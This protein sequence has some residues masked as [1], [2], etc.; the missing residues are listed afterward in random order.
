MDA[1][2][3]KAT[4]YS[5]ESIDKTWYELIDKFPYFI[6][7]DEFILVHAGFDFDSPEPYCETDEMLWIRDFKYNKQKALNKT[8]IRG[9]VPT[10]LETIIKNVQKRE[11]IISLDNGC[12]YTGIDG[13]GHLL[14]LNLNT[15]ELIIQPNIDQ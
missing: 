3:Q 13:L 5:E 8:I 11:P 1:E 15:F 7:L 14:C 12:V 2:L 4:F 9:H 6:E 10:P